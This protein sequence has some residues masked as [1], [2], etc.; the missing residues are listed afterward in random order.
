MIEVQ[1]KANALNSY[2]TSVFGSERNVPQTQPTHSSEPFTNN[3]KIIRKQLEAIGRNKSVGPDVIPG[4]ILKL[5]V[6]AM[7]SYLARFLDTTV[8]NATKPG[9]WKRATVVSIYIRGGRSAVTSYRPV[10]FNLS[11]VQAM[12]HAIAGYLTQVWDMSKW[13]NEGQHGFRPGYWCE[14]QIVTICRT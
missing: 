4:E 3:T 14:S 7:I 10:S 5:G 9:D 12:E 2:Y 1:E 8:N 11:G 6:E 13:L